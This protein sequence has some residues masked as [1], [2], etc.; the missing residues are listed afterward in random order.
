MSVR[1]NQKWIL[2]L[3]PYLIQKNKTAQTIIETRHHK[4]GRIERATFVVDLEDKKTN[5]F[6]GD[7]H[8]YKDKAEFDASRE[9]MA[10]ADTDNLK[11]IKQLEAQ[12]S[13]EINR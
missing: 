2:K 12:K 10:S 3:R 13:S 8:E 9:A 7:Y 11:K 5:N 4:D 6:A 1:K